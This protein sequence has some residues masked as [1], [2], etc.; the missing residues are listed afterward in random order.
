LFSCRKKMGDLSPTTEI[1]VYKQA[2]AGDHRSLDQLMR[3]H[4]GLVQAVVRQQSLGDLPFAEALNAGRVG[5]W[6]AI[7][8]F[9]TQRGLAFSTY[10]WPAIMRQ[11]WRAVKD[12]KRAEACSALLEMS[13]CPDVGDAAPSE[14]AAVQQ[15]LHTLLQRL[16]ERLQRVVIVYYG[17]GDQS[18]ASYRQLGAHMGLSHER[19]RQLH[20]AA[21]AWLRQPAHSQTLRSLLQRHT[22][23]DYEAADALTQRWLRKR[24]G[25]HAR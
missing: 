25:R 23:A 1:P 9:D 5:L 13:S 20:I 4:E 16:P 10:A 21:L 3:R 14:D 22:V 11:V 12:Q 24:G 15:A 17:L 2:Q 8:G 6:H 7:L 19:V 18:P